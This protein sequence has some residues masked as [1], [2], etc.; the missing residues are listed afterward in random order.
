VREEKEEQHVFFFSSSSFST[1]YLIDCFK[2]YEFL[3][4]FAFF[5]IFSTIGKVILKKADMNVL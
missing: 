2:I 4:C 5:Y 1:C 3:S